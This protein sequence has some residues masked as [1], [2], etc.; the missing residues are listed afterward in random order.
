MQYY[1]E[2][3][4]EKS[5][6]FLQELKNNHRFVLI[7]GWAV[8]L[9]SHSLKSKDIDIIIDYPELAKLRESY[10]VAKNDR[11]KKYEI[12]TGEFDVDIY[13]PHYS[14]L[15][16]DIEEIQKNSITKEGFI[17]PDLER[18]FLLKLFAFSQRRGSSK[19]QKDELDIFGLAVLPEFDWG[20]Y[21]TLAADLN[22]EKYH[23]LF[24]DLLNK[25]VSV[26]ELGLN[27]QKFAKVKREIKNFLYEI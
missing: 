19:G 26:K 23:D 15:G 7:G 2:I 5:F 14:E 22:F 1:H 13:L 25:T 27:E 11:L 9:Y 18:L 12:K 24:S 10:D 17:V 8:F 3:I 4:T 16:I 6:K 20:K 21:R